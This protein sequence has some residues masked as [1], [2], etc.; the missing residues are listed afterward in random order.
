MALG[1]WRHYYAF[2]IIFIQIIKRSFYWLEHVYVKGSFAQINW[3]KN[4]KATV[5][6]IGISSDWTARRSILL[7]FLVTIICRHLII[8][9]FFV[10]FCN[11]PQLHCVKGK[12]FRFIQRLA[13]ILS[14]SVILFRLLTYFTSRLLII[15]M[16]QFNVSSI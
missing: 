3:K 13:F 11:L 12:A 6:S 2:T 10:F 14:L 4:W 15:L 1:L 9:T 7:I 16:I 5:V 8:K